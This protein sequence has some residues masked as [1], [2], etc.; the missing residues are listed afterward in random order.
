MSLYRSLSLLLT[1]SWHVEHQAPLVIGPDSVPE[2]DLMV[3]RGSLRDYPDRSPTACDVAIVI[4]VADFSVA[5]DSITKLKAYAAD[6]VPIYWIVNLPMRRIE[7]Y[8]QP[9]GTTYQEKREYGPDDEV[10]VVLDGREVGRVSAKE[11]LP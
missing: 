7:A 8:A 10:P 1:D 2:P 4:E 9:L 6:K 3:V 5:Q 11:I